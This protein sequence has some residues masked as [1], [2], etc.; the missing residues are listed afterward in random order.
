MKFGELIFEEIKTPFYLLS[1]G[2]FSSFHRPT[3]SVKKTGWYPKVCVYGTW[4]GSSGCGC[5][6][7]VVGDWDVY[8]VVNYPIHN[9]DSGLRSRNTGSGTA[10]HFL[11]CHRCAWFPCHTF[12]EYSMMGHFFIAAGA[13]LKVMLEES[14]DF[15][16]L[17][18]LVDMLRP[19]CVFMERYASVLGSVSFC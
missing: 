18:C 13:Q 19:R 8:K 2:R 12:H 17:C 1:L 9:G 11:S 4:N 16:F 3:L 10:A 15:C 6:C 5:L 14:T 7:E